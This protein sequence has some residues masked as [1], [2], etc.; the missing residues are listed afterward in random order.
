[1]YQLPPPNNKDIFNEMLCE[2]FNEMDCSTSYQTFGVNGQK[3]KGIDI[4]S[5]EKG[6]VIQNKFKELRRKDETIREELLNDIQK[7]SI[8]AAQLKFGFVRFILASTFKNDVELQE[9]A[10]MLSDNNIFHVEYWGWNTIEKNLVKYPK[11][12]KK[13]YPVFRVCEYIQLVSVTIERE[14]GCWEED[15]EGEN[16]FRFI[17][18]CKK[19]ECPI[20]NFSFINHKDE[21]V[22]LK[23]IE[24]RVEHIYSGL[25]GIPKSGV[26]KPITKYP[27]EL[28]FR[29]DV[30][31]IIPSRPVYAEAKQPFMFQ[32][33]L[34]NRIDSQMI[35][36]FTFHFNDEVV[37]SPR[38]YMNCNENFQGI[39]VFYST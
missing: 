20:L 18:D 29:K 36:A 17:D 35:F 4:Y 3:Q 1:M 32:V 10:A 22:L 12:I 23:G 37:L 25:H 14:K 34:R 8:D 30:N 26:L 27:I 16:S 11:L 24:I 2:L 15:E 6:T 13:Y 7:E 5:E 19:S 28:D 21:T 31:K 33:E 39:K 9:E 38:V